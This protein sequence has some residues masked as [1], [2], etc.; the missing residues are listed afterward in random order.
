M[1]KKS[2]DAKYVEAALGSLIS[3]RL[4][5]TPE[6]VAIWLTAKE[7]F[8]SA[9]FPSNVWKNDDPLSTGEKASLA[10]VMKEASS[11]NA[12]D[13]ASQAAQGKGMWSSNLNFAWDVILRLQYN[14][15]QSPGWTQNKSSK[16]K[17]INFV[18]FWVE[19]VD[20]K[21]WDLVADIVAADLFQTGYLPHRAPMSANIGASYCFQRSYTKPHSIS[22][23]SFSPGT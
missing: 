18:D 8:P 17:R 9:E 2:F 22:L 16:A 6:G 12:E 11:G 5:R 19:T 10:A 21:Y 14:T 23:P 13:G 4:G 3:H 1:A 20:R 7:K 15:E